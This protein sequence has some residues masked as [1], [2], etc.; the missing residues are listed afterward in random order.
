M[1]DD[2]KLER[3]LEG[4]ESAVLAAIDADMDGET[5]DAAVAGIVAGVLKAYGYQRDGSHLPATR[6]RGRQ[7]GRGPVVRPRIRSRIAR[8]PLRA[9]FSPP[10]DGYDDD[11]S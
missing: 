6:R 7:L 1:T 9:S 10:S 3:L 8:E 11:E 2:D 4:F 5:G